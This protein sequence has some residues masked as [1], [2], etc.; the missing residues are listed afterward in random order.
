[1]S[2]QKLFPVLTSIAII[3]L[4]AL[5]RDRSRAVAAV[6]ATMPINIPLAL[7]VVSSGSGNDP[8]V[9]SDFVRSLLISLIPSFI[10]LG[11]VFLAV[12]AG[13]NLLVVLGAGYIVWGAL[14][15]G[16]FW[17]GVLAWPKGM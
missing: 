1:M 7:W 8:Q 11:V 2:F 17:F 10:W 13:W 15:M 12:R 9:M 4:V 6:L 14:I 16:L 3:I 5:L